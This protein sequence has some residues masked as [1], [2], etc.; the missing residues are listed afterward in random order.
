MK[1][2]TKEKILKMS[3]DLILPVKIT[4]SEFEL[5]QITHPNLLPIQLIQ[6]LRQLIP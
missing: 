4:H 1:K 5:E 6:N 2:R 3:I